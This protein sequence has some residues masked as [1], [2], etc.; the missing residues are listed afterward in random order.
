MEKVLE[1][2]ETQPQEAQR[3]DEGDNRRDW[4]RSEW[5]KMWLELVRRSAVQ[6]AA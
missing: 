2:I 3:T 5:F 6:K 1:G 4:D